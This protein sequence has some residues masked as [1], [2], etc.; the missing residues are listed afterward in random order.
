MGSSESS[1]VQVPQGL[2]VP[3]SEEVIAQLVGQVYEAAPPVEQSRLIECLLKPLGVLSL[4]YVANGIFASMVFRGDWPQR[5]ILPE[6]AQSVQVSDVVSLVHHVQQ[7]SVCA[8]NGLVQVLGASP[9]MTGS[10]AA[11]VLMSVLMQRAKT[12]R[13]SDLPGVTPQTVMAA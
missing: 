13:A 2:D 6:D 12:R 11:A 1:A 9:M 7:V 10:A 5:H 4:A 8:I 3:V